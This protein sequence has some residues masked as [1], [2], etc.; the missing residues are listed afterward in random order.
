MTGV[1]TCALPIYVWRAEKGIPEQLSPELAVELFPAIK[2][3]L[4]ALDQLHATQSQR[5][6]V[7]Q[8][9][10]NFEETSARVLVAA[11]RDDAVRG[12]P[13][14][15]SLHTLH[16][17]IIEDEKT[18]A[19]LDGIQTGIRNAGKAVA[20]AEAEL[21][22][23]ESAH[24]STLAEAGV[25]DD[26]SFAEVVQSMRLRVELEGKVKEG[27][28]RIE[29]AI[30]KGSDAKAIRRELESGELS[31]WQQRRI[32]ER[33]KVEQLR[34]DRDEA[35]REHQDKRTATAQIASSADVATRGIEVEGQ[36]WQLT[37]AIGEWERVVLARSLIEE[38]L[39]RFEQKNQPQVVALAAQLFKVVTEGRYPEVVSG[40]DAL[41]VISETGKRID[42][43]DL[44]T[45]TVQQL[46]LCLRLALAGE[47]AEKGTAL[48]LIMDDVLVNFDPERAAQVA[49]VI[50]DISTRHQVLLLTCHPETR[51]LVEQTA[52]DA[53]V[54][55]LERFA[56]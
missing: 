53:R 24:Q 49:Q 39:S 20:E 21:R 10:T 51:A 2:T 18:R 44:S 6:R 8:R 48:P 43:V 37:K 16:A 19:D 22:E 28:R 3:T 5:E 56:G 1:Q 31:A 4:D 40:E 14:A 27:S 54:I 55:E 47:F 42:V 35:L 45:G 7:W 46:Y 32:Q 23:A 50:A 25:S 34:K 11:G 29:A 26:E 33:Q 9:V 12:S 41:N 13:L 38:T 15:A 52:P 17:N 36:R 30:G